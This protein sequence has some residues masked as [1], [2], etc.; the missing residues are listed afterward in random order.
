M[1]R[2]DAAEDVNHR[3]MLAQNTQYT[4]TVS[5]TLTSDLK[6]RFE[7]HATLPVSTGMIKRPGRGSTQADELGDSMRLELLQGTTE[8]SGRTT[9]AVRRSPESLSMDL[10][11]SVRVS[12]NLFLFGGLF[13]ADLTANRYTIRGVVTVFCRPKSWKHMTRQQYLH[14]SGSCRQEKNWR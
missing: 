6:R 8:D 1:A 7:D 9:R 14:G 4:R 2:T 13:L 12:T 10:G 3:S 5:R 11:E